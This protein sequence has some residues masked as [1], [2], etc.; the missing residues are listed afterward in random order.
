M[1]SGHV[2]RSSRVYI[3]CVVSIQSLLI[4]YIRMIK[5]ENCTALVLYMKNK[6][7]H[8]KGFFAVILGCGCVLLLNLDIFI[9]PLNQNKNEHSQGTQNY[10]RS[11]YIIINIYVSSVE[12][13]CQNQRR[14]FTAKPYFPPDC[15]CYKIAKEPRIGGSHAKD[16]LVQLR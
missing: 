9:F 11:I 3:Y 14:Q 16:S 10:F 4:S 12:R 1:A 15:L 2:V 5:K 7:Y 13:S 6:K 8:K